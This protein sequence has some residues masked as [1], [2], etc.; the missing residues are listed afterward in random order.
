[1]AEI[2]AKGFNARVLTFDPYVKPEGAARI[3][4]QLVDLETLLKESDIIMLHAPLT[5]QTY[6]VIGLLCAL[7]KVLALACTWGMRK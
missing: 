3:G 7:Q 5:P 6:H 1:M 2:F 4:A